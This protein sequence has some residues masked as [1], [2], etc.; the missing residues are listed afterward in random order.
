MIYIYI[1]TKIC[2]IWSLLF[3][4]TCFIVIVIIVSI[5]VNIIILSLVLYLTFFSNQINTKLTIII[6]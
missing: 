6:D 1:Y 2:T 5:V 3:Y 4:N